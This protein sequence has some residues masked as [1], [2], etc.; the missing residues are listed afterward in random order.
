M[1]RPS[2]FLAGRVGLAAA[3]LLRRISTR[4]QTPL[5]VPQC[6]AGLANRVLNFSAAARPALR[7]PGP[8]PCGTGLAPSLPAQALQV[9]RTWFLTQA[10]KL[11]PSGDIGTCLICAE[12]STA[13]FPRCFSCQA[14]FRRLHPP[15]DRATTWAEASPPRSSLS[16]PLPVTRLCAQPTSCQGLCIEAG[17]A[18]R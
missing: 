3:S 14:P 1:D 17:G 5:L 10:P 15:A 7:E 11:H 18:G 2:S 16:Q 4:R 8:A 6:S 13:S 12:F 9:L